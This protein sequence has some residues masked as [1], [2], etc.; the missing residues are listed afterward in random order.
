LEIVIPYLGE[1]PFP[2]ILEAYA[3][4]DDPLMT[5]EMIFKKFLR[6]RHINHRR[7]A[8]IDKRSDELRQEIRDLFVDLSD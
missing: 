6:K 7:N 4:K 1:V 5:F 3:Q 2:E 8:W